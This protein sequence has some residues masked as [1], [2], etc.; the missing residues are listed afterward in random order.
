M[1]KEEYNYEKHSITIDSINKDSVDIIIQSEIITANLKIDEL[2]K[3]DLD[4]DGTYDL[5]VRLNAIQNG[6]AKIY[7]EKTNTPVCSES[8]ICS[9]WASC[10][11]NMQL[12][13]C[14]DLNHCGTFNEKPEE[15]QDCAC[16]ENWSCSI[17]EPCINE[18]QRRYCIDENH[19]ETYQDKPLESRDCSSLS[20]SEL[21]GI[22]CDSDKVCD[23]TTTITLNSDNCCLGE[24]ILNITN[25]IQEVLGCGI[26]IDCLDCNN[27]LNCFINAAQT[28][29]YSNITYISTSNILG[30]IE[31]IISY[32]ELR[33]MEGDK[34]LFYSKYENIDITFS[35]EFIQDALDGGTTQGEIDQILQ[36]TNQ[37]FDALEGKD[38]L[39][40][41]TIQDLINL[42]E[43]WDE[44]FF[45]ISVGGDCTGTLEDF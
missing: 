11:N 25:E 39:C 3:F 18:K 29:E 23:G 36:D 35:E 41:N 27:N 14:T 31:N 8:W 30:I 40:K 42:F 43:N 28:C 17:W 12:R 20:C 2:K 37:D 5:I 44:G 22:I 33:G 24:C 19:C 38:S 15:Q 32:H 45:L 6:E 10:L 34:C 4:K 26:D 1:F 13:A 16:L 21:N 7:M 9:E